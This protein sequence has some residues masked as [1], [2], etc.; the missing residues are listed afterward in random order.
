M[1]LHPHPGMGGDRHHP[2]VVRV[3]DG[4]ASAGVA[5][6]RLDIADPD[7]PGATALLDTEAQGFAEAVGVDRLVLIGYSWGSIVAAGARP[8]GLVAR[9]LVAPPGGLLAF[10]EAD[11]RPRLVLVPEHDQ[12]GDP[13]TV[14]EAMAS[15]PATT[16]ETVVGIDHFLVGAVDRIGARVVTWVDDLLS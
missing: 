14:A 15:W 6:L 10:V 16:I 11:D 12:F 4:L 1:V 7:P 9:V 2:L 3:A 8:G 13:E 5:A